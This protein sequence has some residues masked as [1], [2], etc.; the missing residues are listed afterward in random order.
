MER[1]LI[2]VFIIL[3][4]LLQ[5]NLASAQTNRLEGVL[6]MAD[7][8][9]VPHA[10]VRLKHL[11]NRILSFHSS[12][13]E[14]RFQL[15]VSDTATWSELF[16]EVHHLG[17]KKINHPLETGVYR[18][19]ITMEEQAINLAEIAIKNRPKIDSYGDTLSY[20]VASFA[21]AEDRT[22]GDVLRNMPGMEVSESGQIKY[23]DKAI[24]NLYIDGD[25]LLADKYAI[26]TRTI[27]H[28]MVEK[29]QVMQNH[30]PLRVLRNKTFSDQVALNLVIKEE[31]KLKMTGQA[32]IGFGLPHQYDAELNTILFNKKYKML[33]VAKGNN[34]GHDLNSDFASLGL[35]GIL[36]G[37]SS[38]PGALLHTGIGTPALQK[39]RYFLNN[40][41]SINAN[42]LI[43]LSNGWQ[44]KA[45]LRGLIDHNEQEAWQRT[46]IYSSADTIRY[47]QNQAMKRDPFVTELTLDAESNKD[48]YFFKN[49]LKLN[50]KGESER[51]ILESNAEAFTQELRHRI[52]DFSNEMRYVPEL[53]NGNIVHLSWLLG[54][55]SRPQQLWVTPGL[56]ADVLN[57]GRDFAQIDQYAEIPAWSNRLSLGYQL[58]KG[59]I[60]QS[61]QLSTSSE[62]QRLESEL[63]LQQLD[64]SLTPFLGSED[65]DLDW[66]KHDI[67]LSGTYEYKHGRLESSLSLP[68]IWQHI[69]Y[70]DRA[71]D[72]DVNRSRLLFSPTFRTKWM[73]TREDYV[74]FNYNYGEQTGTI[75]G[76][77]R[78]AIL[79]GY[80]S[81]KANASDLNESRG[82]SGSLHY[83][84]QRSISMLFMNAGLN[85]NRS[86][87]NSISST[88]MTDQIAQT[89]LIPF[90]NDV[91]SFGASAGI[92]KFIFGLGATAG[93][94]GA[95]S[96][97]RANQILNGESLP[98]HNVNW[99]ISPV[100]EARLWRKVSMSYEGRGSR[101]T[102]RS[103]REVE[104][105]ILS[106]RTIQQHNQQVSLS[107][108]P[109]NHVFLRFTAR[110]Q[111]VSQPGMQDL[112]YYFM[113]AKI[114]YNLRKWRTDFD[115][116]LTNL[117]NVKNYETFTLTANQFGHSRFELRGRM[118][119]LKA[120]FNL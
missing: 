21:R 56:N 85:Y 73:T 93:L 98:F 7:G 66:R 59:K 19:D 63:R 15:S 80:R 105:T 18:Y 3:G 22:I 90:D 47:G 99:S 43:N 95:W 94:K 1:F 30:Q 77:Y 35:G 100:I 70:E 113:D 92:S 120:S 115:L 13:V 14:G 97:T 67:S 75:A 62:I 60:R 86:L 26:G 34:I 68:L 50:Y 5:V 74:T 16:I 79:T 118:A 38:K 110:Q 27:P 57:E 2:V 39:N 108:S 29:L 45:N 72:L 24:S 71:F 102:S 65:N 91:S 89:I 9:A 28:N 116:D 88:I 40:S 117:A 106:D 25:D 36:S 104:A 109:R 81:L 6:K 83:N 54:Y 31:A 96:T 4:G 32:K 87:S 55:F 114:R 69:T 42:N 119:V 44:L 64:Q 52:R 107:Y 37:G 78:G 111:Y 11:S 46:E 33:N 20:D 8:K 76:I 112:N 17:Y 49:A 23:N 58:P 10:S 41:G 101:T 103:A 82:H 61:Y 48:R 53:R 51:S 84:F 12:D